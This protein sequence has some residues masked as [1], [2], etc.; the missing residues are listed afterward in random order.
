MTMT[1]MTKMTNLLA[2]YQDQSQNQRAIV[3]AGIRWQ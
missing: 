2:A 1:K 3:F